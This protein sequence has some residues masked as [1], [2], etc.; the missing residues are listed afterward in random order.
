MSVTD[1]LGPVFTL[2]IIVNAMSTALPL[3]WHRFAWYF[4]V[5]ISFGLAGLF[6]M[7]A[8][9]FLLADATVSLYDVN[10][11]GQVKPQTTVPFDPATFF[12]VNVTMT[13]LMATAV[14]AMVAWLCHQSRKG[15]Y[16]YIVPMLRD[17]NILEQTVWFNA[18]DLRDRIVPNSL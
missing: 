3:L 18:L 15:W 13:T 6:L 8:I 2:L 7:M 10:A 12:L 4:L 9:I 5:F 17:L 1:T 14:L 11:K 16:V